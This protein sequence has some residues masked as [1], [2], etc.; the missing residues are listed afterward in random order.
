MAYENIVLEFDGPIAVLTI[1]RPD[2]LNALNTD[3][4]SEMKEAVWEVWN[5]KGCRVMLLTG[6]GDKAF[7]AGADI[8]QMSE[9]N[10]SGAT[11]FAELG[12]SVC[13]MLEKIPRVV[14]AAVN[15]YALGGG[16]EVS[17][18]CDIIFA[19]TKAVFAQPEV[20]LGVV[21]GFGGTVRLPRAIGRSA[22]CEW[23]LAGG[24]FN[25]DEALR[26]GLVSRVCDP[27]DLIDDA[28]GLARTIASR[29][30]EAVRVAKRLIHDGLSVHP[31][32]ALRTEAAVFA[33]LFDTHE[34]KEG[35]SA[36]LDKRR[37]EFDD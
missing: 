9:M 27:E 29:G 11:R 33:N 13:S 5:W 34:Q 8:A 28:M 36:F 6:S 35:M 15:G 22:A 16:C 4:L 7:V 21:P 10:P 19:S 37:P 3:V 32:A 26:L 24:T 20:K 30:P 25:A 1:D 2:V 23:I 12:H 18:A 17:L 14:I 31:D